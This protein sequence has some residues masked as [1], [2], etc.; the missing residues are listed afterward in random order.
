MR[1]LPSAISVPLLLATAVAGAAPASPPPVPAE[2]TATVP[3]GPTGAA[4]APMLAVAEN[5]LPETPIGTLVLAANAK[6]SFAVGVWPAAPFQGA[7]LVV[8]VAAPGIASAHGRFAGKNLRFYRFD[9]ST[10]RGIAPVPND[11]P[12]GPADLTLEVVFGAGKTRRIEKRSVPLSVAAVAYDRDELRVDP[13]FTKLSAAARAQIAKDKEFLGKVWGRGSPDQPLFHGNFAVPRK[14]R[15]TAPYG[16]R[17]TFNGQVKSVH[18]GWDIDGD[19]GDP[20]LCTNE[21]I[22]RVAR[23]LYFSGGTLIIDHGAG[24]Y[25]VYFH[26]SDYW[27]KEGQKVKRD[28]PCAKVGNSGRVTGPHLH[29]GARV[30]G[31]YIHPELLLQFDFQAPL[32]RFPDGVPP[33][34]G[35]VIPAA[36]R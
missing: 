31:S 25:S 3:A 9:A 23:E 21:G 32:V 35:E 17:R 7:L 11:A 10:L 16:T 27:V 8:D 5:G 13:K 36:V 24:I 19:I 12:T 14:D 22:V 2:T 1:S 15:T 30:G 26:L 4:A 33:A 34:G 20:I 28:Q 6:S 29:F 18:A